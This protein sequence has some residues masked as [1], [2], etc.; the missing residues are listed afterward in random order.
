MQH[1]VNNLAII[2]VKVAMLCL[3]LMMKVRKAWRGWK[4]IQVLLALDS[5]VPQGLLELQAPPYLGTQD[6]QAWMAW[7]DFTVNL[8]LQVTSNQKHQ[9]STTCY[10]IGSLDSRGLWW[11]CLVCNPGGLNLDP[12]ASVENRVHQGNQAMGQ[13]VNLDLKEHL[14]Q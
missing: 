13:M 6:P 10:S 4:E 5:Q 11:L 9:I 12:Q 3:F 2:T 8:G 14:G 1:E 7:V